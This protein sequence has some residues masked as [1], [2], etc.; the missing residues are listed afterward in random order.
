MK[1]KINCIEFSGWVF[2]C[3]K[4]KNEIYD[5]KHYIRRP[6]TGERMFCPYCKRKFKI[7]IE[8]QIIL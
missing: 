7:N 3:P 8:E 6:I 2:T 5:N 1:S 4:C